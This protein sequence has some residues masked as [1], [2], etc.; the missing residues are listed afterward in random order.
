MRF[1]FAIFKV[2]FF[3]SLCGGLS[4]SIVYIGFVLFS[5]YLG[6]CGFPVVCDVVLCLF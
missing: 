5:L 1:V 6:V 4:F 2:F 3:F